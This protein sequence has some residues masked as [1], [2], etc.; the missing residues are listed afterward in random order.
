MDDDKILMAEKHITLLELMKNYE[1]KINTE[2]AKDILEDIGI[3]IE[4]GRFFE[5]AEI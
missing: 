3:L 4:F 5:E 1:S 2:Y